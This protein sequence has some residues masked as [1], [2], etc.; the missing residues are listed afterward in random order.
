MLHKLGD[1]ALR[2]HDPFDEAKRAVARCDLRFEPP[3][4]LTRACAARYAEL[5]TCAARDCDLHRVP[6][7]CAPAHARARAACGD[8][9]PL[10]R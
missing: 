10:A 5:V 6:P 2:L 9:L 4:L 3:Q 1:I 8:V 7:R